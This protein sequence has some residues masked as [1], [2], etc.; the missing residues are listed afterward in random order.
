MAIG[1]APLKEIR[2]VSGSDLPDD[3]L[4]KSA[5]SETEPANFKGREPKTVPELFRARVSQW[6]DR[7]A[8]NEKKLGL[9][10]KIT[11]REYGEK[12]RCVALALAS[13][14]LKHGDRTTIMSQD[15]P[16][17][18]FA[19]MGNMCAGG[20]SAG[21]Y[22]TDSPQQVQ[23]ILNHCGA[24]FHFVED[25]EQLDK[26]LQVRDNIPSLVKVIVFDMEGLR[27]FKDDQ[28][29]SFHELLDVGNKIYEQNT[30][31]FD[32]LL[33]RARPEDCAIIIYTSGTTGPPKGAMM[34]HHCALKAASI[35]RRVM[36]LNKNDEVLCFLPLCHIAERAI[37][38]LGPLQQGYVVSFAESPETVPDN[39]REV[40]PTVFCSVPRIWEKF[41]SNLMLTIQDATRFQQWTFNLA[42][43]VGY[44]MS[45]YRQN[46]TA[47]PWHLSALFQAL[48][49]SVLRNVKK[50]VGL[51]RVRI[52][53][54]GAAPISKDLLNFYHALGIDMREGYGQTESMGTATLH[55]QN[56]NKF[57]TVG[58]PLPEI[59]I[60]IAED[61]EI[62]IK[63]P[64]I[65]MGYFNEPV[66]TAETV[67]DGWLYT[68]DVGRIDEDGHVIITDRKKD[69]II[70]A[71]GKNI[72]PSEIENELKFNPYINDA[73]VIGD[74]RKY[75]TA[76]IMIDDENVMK[77]A[78]DNR[79]PF[80]TYKSLTQQAEIIQL[81][82]REIRKANKNVA[83][84]ETIKKFRLIDIQLTT[85][86]D[87]ITP[88]GK[89][90]RKFVNEKF[91][92]VIESMY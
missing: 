57:G 78:Q 62:L 29:M 65:F 3:G 55:R 71:G 49:W 34:A 36:P 76:L 86:D 11:W 25:E 88:T 51:D 1:K 19:D 92:D 9:W 91:K 70:T 44:K 73:V 10:Q 63:S 58:P 8:M 17:W 60:K 85:D 14:G 46:C 13:M 23:Y 83:R 38:S 64:T 4:A 37:S 35:A 48:N 53:V 52:C 5:T 30:Q 56:G 20:I 24:K 66:K 21:V 42:L 27:Y 26:L 54:S 32:K 43:S 39:I 50:T 84:V 67:K 68:G 7:V 82:D 28:V 41:Y 77:Y 90:K 61:G 33:T 69:I 18:L 40:S 6:A 2:H 72:T 47:P 89:L 45:A 31:W 16:E 87:E 12:A 15:N 75:L 74:G 22:P 81:I 59:E 79:I 80:T